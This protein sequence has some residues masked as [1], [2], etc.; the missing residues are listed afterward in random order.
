MRR[1]RER[2]RVGSC[3][4][5]SKSNQANEETVEKIKKKS[6]KKTENACRDTADLAKDTPWLSVRADL[7]AWCGATMQK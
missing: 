4:S 3:D 2:E 5:Q 6:R 1:E 7:C